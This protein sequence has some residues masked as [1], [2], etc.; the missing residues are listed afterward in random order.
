MLT[1]ASCIDR[2]LGAEEMK[3][4]VGLRLDGKRLEDLALGMSKAIQTGARNKQT[5]QIQQVNGH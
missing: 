3:D 1:H 2:S 4:W 5:G